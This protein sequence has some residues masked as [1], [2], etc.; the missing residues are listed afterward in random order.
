VVVT[1]TALFPSTLQGPV[2]EHA[3][4][5]PP[6]VA[7]AA[8]VAVSVTSVPPGYVALQPLPQLIP[9]GLLVTVPL[10]LPLLITLML[11]SD[12]TEPHA[13]PEYADSPVLL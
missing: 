5:Q 11:E 7:P 6:N 9:E 2:P 13:S 10:P 12:G 4:L 8:G 3:P 1:V